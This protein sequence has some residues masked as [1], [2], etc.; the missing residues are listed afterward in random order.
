MRVS[1]VSTCG[2]CGNTEAGGPRHRTRCTTGGEGSNRRGDSRYF[3][4]WLGPGSCAT[5]LSPTLAAG[6]VTCWPS[7]TGMA[8]RH[9]STLATISCL[10]WSRRPRTGLAQMHLELRS[11]AATYL[12][13]HPTAH[14]TSCCPR[15]FL[16]SETGNFSS[17]WCLRRSVGAHN[18]VLLTQAA[19][20]PSNHWWCRR[21]GRD[22]V[23][24]QSLRRE[25]IRVSSLTHPLRTRPD[26]PV[27]D[28]RP[29]RLWLAGRTS[30]MCPDTR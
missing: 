17:R 7:S 19:E 6:V 29:V 9:A 11:S 18:T 4:R 12:C 21:H 2:S 20:V 16:P 13:V 23:H 25:G 8:L 3:W 30:G 26:H 24:L 22:S 10:K 5:P 28:Q 27:P 1:D 14:S 15:E